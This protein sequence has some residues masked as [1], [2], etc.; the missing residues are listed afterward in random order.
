[1]QATAD[2]VAKKPRAFANGNAR[3]CSPSPRHCCSK[4]L[5]YRPSMC[6]SIHV[7]AKACCRLPWVRTN[8]SR[9]TMYA[10]IGASAP[11]RRGSPTRSLRAACR[12]TRWRWRPESPAP[13]PYSRGS[14]SPRGSVWRNW[15]CW[16]TPCCGATC[17]T[18]ATRCKTLKTCSCILGT[19]PAIRAAAGRGRPEA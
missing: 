16:E 7:W 17:S 10:A 13:R 19:A 18:N 11:N 8:T 1:M 14:F 15:W 5:R 2:N 9:G 12:W 6:A 3:A 4:A